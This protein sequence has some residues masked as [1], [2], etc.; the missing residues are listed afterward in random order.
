MIVPLIGID[1]ALPAGEG[2]KPGRQVGLD[3]DQA[4][5]G[6]LGFV[7]RHVDQPAG[8]VDV[9]PI[10]AQYFTGPQPGKGADHQR[11]NEFQGGGRQKAAQLLRLKDFRR[12]G[13]TIEL[14]DY[15]DR[16]G[17]D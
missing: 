11:W 4:P 5:P 14:V 16:V 9:L 17:I 8:Q 2:A 1:F 6:S 10:Q 12:L 3:R 13:R 15:T 7:A